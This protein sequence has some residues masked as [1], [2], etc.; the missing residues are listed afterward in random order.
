MFLAICRKSLIYWVSATLGPA[1]R[2]LAKHGQAKLG[3]AGPGLAGPRLADALCRGGGLCI[4]LIDSNKIAT[5]IQYH[6][7]YKIHLIR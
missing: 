6:F 4:N 5:A 1:R 3:Q 7:T 2:D